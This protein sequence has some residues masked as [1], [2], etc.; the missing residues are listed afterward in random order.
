[1]YV[2]RRFDDSNQYMVDLCEFAEI[3]KSCHRSELY[4]SFLNPVLIS[5]PRSRKRDTIKPEFYTHLYIYKKWN[6]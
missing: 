3:W 5:Y 2:A 4:S 6:T 1:M